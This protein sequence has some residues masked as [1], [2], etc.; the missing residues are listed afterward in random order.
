MNRQKPS[1]KNISPSPGSAV[2]RSRKRRRQAFKSFLFICFSI[3]VVGALGSAFFHLPIWRIEKVEVSGLHVIPEEEIQKL[4]QFVPGEH[5]FMVRLGK[6]RE[7]VEKF[8]P[9]RSVHVHRIFPNRIAVEIVERTPKAILIW[10]GGSLLVDADGVLLTKRFP[11]SWYEGVDINL[12][13]VIRGIPKSA[14]QGDYLGADYGKAVLQ[15]LPRLLAAIPTKK[16]QLDLKMLRE[17]NILLDDLVR[18]D[19]GGMEDLD[20]KM[21]LLVGILQGLGQKWVKLEYIDL[22]I[23]DQPVYKFKS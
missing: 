11:I 21:G 20:K 4:V 3:F 15:I 13:P 5:M 22:R 7:V 2:E 12:L 14:I 19:L 23:L 8:P 18:V 6:V 16:F 1:K 9:V 17:V 10:E